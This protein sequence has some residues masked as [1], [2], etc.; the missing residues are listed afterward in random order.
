[1]PE[2]LKSSNSFKEVFCDKGGHDL[3]Q[4]TDDKDKRICQICQSYFLVSDNEQII[5]EITQK[6]FYKCLR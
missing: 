1:M 6:E 3:R 5:K 4:I 2:K